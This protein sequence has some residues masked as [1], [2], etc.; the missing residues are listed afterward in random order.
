M[1]HRQQAAAAC[2]VPI[3]SGGSN[4]NAHRW[5]TSLIELNGLRLRFV[6]PSD[7]DGAGASSQIWRVSPVTVR[8]PLALGSRHCVQR[9]ELATVEPPRM[10]EDIRSC[11]RVPNRVSEP[12]AN[13]KI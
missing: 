13:T 7:Y 10:Y 12:S 1:N 8:Q 5:I 4:T 6:R 2:A 9:T 11:S 3:A